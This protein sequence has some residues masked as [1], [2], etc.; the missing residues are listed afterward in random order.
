MLEQFGIFSG[1]KI[2]ISKTQILMLNCSPSQELKQLQLNWEMKTIRYL[3]INIPKNLMKLY[4]RNY[5]NID[6]VIR[7]DIECWFS[8]LMGLNERIR[9]IKMNILPRL[10]YL[11]QSLPVDIPDTQFNKW[12]K[13]ISR[14]LWQGKRPRIGYST[15]QIPK[16]RGGM[17]LPNLKEYF[18]AAQLRPLLYTGVM[19]TI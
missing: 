9:T 19:M 7:K 11:F 3:G 13:L 12:D 17:A 1:Y 6:D 5:E 8:Y 18:Q 16:D 15:L 14:F 10:L 2:N 4:K